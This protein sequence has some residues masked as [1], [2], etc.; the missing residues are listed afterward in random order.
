MQNALFYETDIN[1]QMVSE[2]IKSSIKGHFH[3]FFHRLYLPDFFTGFFTGFDH[4]KSA[5][6]TGFEIL[7]PVKNL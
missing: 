2:M 3:R 6:F 1:F 4:V 5:L 7:D